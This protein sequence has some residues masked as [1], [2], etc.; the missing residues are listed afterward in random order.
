M[1]TPRMPARETA[2]IVS[3][4]QRYDREVYELRLE[5]QAMRDR[6]VELSEELA[7]LKAKKARKRWRR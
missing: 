2:E 6:L 4:R 1:I 7:T 5:L 3:L